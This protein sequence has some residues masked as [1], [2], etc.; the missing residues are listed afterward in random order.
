MIVIDGLTDSVR[1]N[2]ELSPMY[3]R[4]T[5]CDSPLLLT[6]D[7]ERSAPI[8][9]VPCTC[10]DANDDHRICVAPAASSTRL[11]NSN[12]ACCRASSC[13]WKSHQND[14]LPSASTSMRPLLSS[15]ERLSRPTQW[16]Y[17]L[18]AST[19]GSPHIGPFSSHSA[20]VK[21]IGSCTVTAS[22]T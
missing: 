2:A 10:V 1:G 15:F 7:L 22:T 5:S 18:A 4:L 13:G 3:K 20:T 14:S 16:R 19:S 6:T 9:H 17:F 21:P 11:E 8:R 12:A